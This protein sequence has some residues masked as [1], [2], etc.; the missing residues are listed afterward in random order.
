MKYFLHYIRKLR[1]VK[2]KSAFLFGK[3]IDEAFNALLTTRDVNHAQ[4]IFLLNMRTTKINSKDVFVEYS[5]LVDYTKKDYDEE[6]VQYHGG[7]QSE[8]LPWYSLCIKGRMI[9]DA[10]AKEILPKIKDVIS[11]QKRVSLKN[12][13]EDEIYGLLDAIVLWE[14]G[15]VYLIDNKTSSV[16]YSENSVR[17][18][19]Q[20]AL[21][22]YIEKDNIKLDG[23]GFIVIDK[24][25]NKN[26]T[27]TCVKCGFTGNGMHKT[28]N[29]VVHGN[30]CGGDWSIS[31]SPSVG[32]STIFSEIQSEDEMRVIDEF[33]KVNNGIA[34]GEFRCGQNGCYSKFGPCIYKKFCETGDMEGLVDLKEKNEETEAEKKDT[35]SISSN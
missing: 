13:I 28:C 18:S 17:E 8:N 16:K 25:I 15:K 19:N 1:P 26:R 7:T 33:D 14:N 2:T 6:L 3:A 34:N 35:R 21:Y 31:I 9:I 5:N 20:L 11:I 23:C 24:N 27:K 32:I 4:E 29:N 10:Y 22:H 12:E 30:R